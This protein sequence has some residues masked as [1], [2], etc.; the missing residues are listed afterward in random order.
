[1]A[2]FREVNIKGIDNS[3][4][5]EERKNRFMNEIDENDYKNSLES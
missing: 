3:G 2:E 5:E 1:M 4:E